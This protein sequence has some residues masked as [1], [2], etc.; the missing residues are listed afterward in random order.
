MVDTNTAAV[1]ALTLAGVLNASVMGVPVDTIVV[2]TGFTMLG[3]MG[4]LGFEMAKAS[5]GADGVKWSK[6]FSLLG[7]SLIS[8]P[9][10]SVICLTVLSLIGI[11]SD[12]ATL[13][14]LVFF[15]FVGPKS[16]LWLFNTGSTL[17]TKK[18]GLTLPGMPGDGK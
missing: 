13:L 4:R 14:G 9:T 17:F 2:A 15:G 16:L 6:V 8:A 18:T 3:A 10:I 11:Q 1:G 7:G 12:K 5:E